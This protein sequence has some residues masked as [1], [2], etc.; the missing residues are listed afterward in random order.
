MK[1]LFPLNRKDRNNDINSENRLDHPGLEFKLFGPDH[2][3]LVLQFLVPKQRSEK[4]KFVFMS[5]FPFLKQM[6][7][8]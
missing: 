8:F 3:N 7:Y 6:P 2:S 4:E 5:S 1:D